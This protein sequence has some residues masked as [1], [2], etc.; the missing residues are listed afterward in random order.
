MIKDLDDVVMEEIERGMDDL[1]TKVEDFHERNVDSELFSV[2]ASQLVTMAIESDFS[3]ID[4]MKVIEI[5]FNTAQH[6]KN[7]QMN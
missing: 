1:V 3:K 7:Q 4:F 6:E 5:Y 2:L